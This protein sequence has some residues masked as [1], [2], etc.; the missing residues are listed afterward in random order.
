MLGLKRNTVVLKPYSPEW[1]IVFQNVKKEIESLLSN[2]KIVIEHIG[3]TSI[4]NMPSK[5]ILDIGIGTVSKKDIFEI[6]KIL[7]NNGWVDRGDRE[8]RGGYLLVKFAGE[9]VISHHLHILET[10]DQQWKNYLLFRNRL[11]DNKQLA[12]E[13]KNLKQRLFEKHKLERG[14]YTDGKAEFIKRVLILNIN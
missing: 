9:E 2:Y 14:N 5:P 12:Y 4:D 10:D 11:R 3:S 6:A 8:D 7:S 1:K 13:Y